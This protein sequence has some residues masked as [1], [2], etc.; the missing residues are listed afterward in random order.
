[1]T[2]ST[3]QVLENRYRIVSLLG[4][5][6]MG[7]V[8]RAWD[9]N[10]R[11]PV[12]L[13]EN[14]D[15]SLVS[16]EQF[17]REAL[18]LAQLNHPNLPRVTNH[19]TVAGQ[20]QYLVMEFIDGQDLQQVLEARGRLTEA[21]AVP[22]IGQIASALAYL[23]SRPEPVIHRDIKPA[24]IK[25]TADNRAVLVDF[26]IAKQYVAEG[27]TTRGAQ[28][29]TPGFS[30]PEQYGLGTTDA[31]SDIYATGATLYALLTGETPVESVSRLAGATLPPPAQLTRPV[32]AAILRAME[33]E[34]NNRFQGAQEFAQALVSPVPVPGPAPA[35]PRRLWPIV[36]AVTL[37]A[38]LVVGF[39]VLR[40]LLNGGGNGDTPTTET[41]TGADATATAEAEAAIG[42]SAAATLT[43]VAVAGE[44]L[45]AAQS[46]ATAAALTAVVAG[47]ADGDGL[48]NDQ[49]TTLDTDPGSPDTDVD[50]LKDG[51]EVLIYTTDPTNRDSDG[52]L[53][54]DFDEV[55]THRT[56]PRASDSDGD[57]V[58]D[59]LEAAQGTDPMVA[60]APGEEANTSETAPTDTP[61]PPPDEG[62]PE[63]VEETIG[64]SAG[65]LPIRLYTLGDGP[66][67]VALVGGIHAGFAPAG[68]TVV[69]RAMAHFQQNPDEIP[70]GVALHFIPNSNPDGDFA[71]G[72][73]AGRFNA[74]G[75]DLNRNFGC[76]WSSDSTTTSGTPLNE[77]SA[78]FSEPETVALRDYFTATRPEV[79]IFY[80]ARA[81]NGLVTPGECDNSIGDT[82]KFAVAYA[83]AS[84]YVY[85]ITDP[86]NGDASNWLISQGIPAFFVLL[87]EYSDLSEGD[88]QDNLGGIRFTTIEAGR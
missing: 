7:A 56:N 21:E 83:T 41:I 26:G 74:N 1:M 9:L 24:N 20:G 4:Q 34:P 68:V 42:D 39:L 23:H 52:D 13:K 28:A 88:W 60:D 81:N 61:T 53:L 11:V 12:A 58:A 67:V 40:S 19:F 38:L 72:E 2:L 55:N 27:R 87:P 86:V 45:A 46:A 22:I 31:R 5:G 77:G 29:V 59:G 75:V 6:G 64:F 78:P 63:L 82:G 3:G 32:A 10:L 76:D 80:E 85:K 84:G 70:D 65:G 17:E 66:R 43:A 73:V 8:Y 71:P 25:I 57:G 62:A 14:L 35:R 18:L 69:E 30:P 79:V 33:M 49:E 37:V 51:D 36:A 15:L 48:S 47:D 50:G 44:E 16:R 54:T